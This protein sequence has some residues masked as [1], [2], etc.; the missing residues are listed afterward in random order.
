[1]NRS[2]DIIRGWLRWLRQ[3]ICFHWIV[4]H[5]PNVIV[6]NGEYAKDICRRCGKTTM[7]YVCD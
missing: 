5:V 2:I 3:A 4:D 7:R 6:T 1:M